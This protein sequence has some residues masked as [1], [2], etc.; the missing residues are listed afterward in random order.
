MN[1]DVLFT[2][3]LNTESYGNYKDNDSKE[4]YPEKIYEYYF[5]IKTPKIFT[6]IR[7]YRST[8]FMLDFNHFFKKMTKKEMLKI[9]TDIE[10]DEN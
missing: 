3:L 7:K 4:K 9:Q 10:E 5:D 1:E 6:F 2:I 8:I